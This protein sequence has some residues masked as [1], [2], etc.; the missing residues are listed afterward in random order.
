M[1]EPVPVVAG[2]CALGE[3]TRLRS[4]ERRYRVRWRFATIRKAKESRQVG[5]EEGFHQTNTGFFF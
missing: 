4:K 1:I 2:K 5:L 3:A